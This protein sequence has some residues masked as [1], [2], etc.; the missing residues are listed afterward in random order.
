MTPGGGLNRDKHLSQSGV[1][2]TH[3]PR[4]KRA[5]PLVSTLASPTQLG[6]ALLALL[7]PGPAPL[8]R[9]VGAA[10][11]V[12]K[13]G[14]HSA[15][16]A[17]LL[18]IFQNRTI[19]TDL[20]HSAFLVVPVQFRRATADYQ[21]SWRTSATGCWHS[22][23]PHGLMSVSARSGQSLEGGTLVEADTLGRAALE[24]TVTH[25]RVVVPGGSPMAVA[26]DS[27]TVVVGD[28]L[29]VAVGVSPMA[30]VGVKEVA[31][32]VS[33]TSPVSQKPT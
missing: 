31:P 2:T 27:L 10:D 18:N 32:T 22:L 24:A 21:P 15:S 26:G 33:G 8:P 9:G 5:Q 19:S 28:N 16:V 20:K 17:G 30:A 7:I 12:G 13:S 23:W 29:T 14:S 4:E 1:L 3:S 11:R 25:L 6:P